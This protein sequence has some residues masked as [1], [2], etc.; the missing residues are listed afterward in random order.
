MESGTHISKLVVVK[1]ICYGVKEHVTVETEG[2][3]DNLPFQ[4]SFNLLG[5]HFNPTGKS[6]ESVEERLQEASEAWRRDARIYRSRDVPW[7]INC[8]RMVDQVYSF[9]GWGSTAKKSRSE[10]CLFLPLTTCAQSL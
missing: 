5:Y 8:K 1:C 4:K 10:W 3:A 2:T 7:R 9:E 6:H